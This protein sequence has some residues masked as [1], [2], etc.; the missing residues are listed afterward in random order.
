MISIIAGCTPEPERTLSSTARAVRGSA[1]TSNK[2]E[3][4]AAMIVASDVLTISQLFSARIAML[5][6]SCSKMI[7]QQRAV[8][9]DAVACLEQAPARPKAHGVVR[10]HGLAEL[11]LEPFD[12]AHRGPIAARHDDGVG[13]RPVD[14][15]AEVVSRLRAG[16]A[17]LDSG[18]V[19]G[20]LA[21]DDFEAARLHEAHHGL[22]H[23]LAPGCADRNLRGA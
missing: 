9:L 22:V 15:A 17:E 11:A 10:E 6:N 21:V 12:D 8:A 5:L 16:A 19:S 3:I 14:P 4:A 13:I 20:D 18:D 2:D 7:A 1:A 23:G